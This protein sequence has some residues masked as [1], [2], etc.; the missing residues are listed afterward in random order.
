MAEANSDEKTE[1]P[2]AKKISKAREEGNVPKSQDVNGFVTMTVAVAGVILLASQIGTRSVNLFNYYFSIMNTELTMDNAMN[3]ALVSFKEFLLIVLPLTF[4]VAT[5]GVI[6]TIGQ[7]GWLFTTKAIKPKFSKLNPINGLKNLIS[8]KKFVEGFK[9]IFKSFTMLI[10]G[11][12]FFWGFVEELPTVVLFDVEAQLAWMYDKVLI[13]VF[14]MLFIMLIYALIDFA[15]TKYNYT[16]QLKMTKQEVKDEHK[17]SEGDPKIKAKIR[18]MQYEMVQKRMMANVPDADVVITNPTHYAV[19]LKYDSEINRAPF[20]TAKGADHIALQI[21][22]IARENGVPV[23]QNPPLARSLYDQV[24]L[25]RP[26]P[27]ELFLAV[28]EVLAYVMKQNK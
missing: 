8:V 1:D 17:N 2:T 18:Q 4:L 10:I 16:K 3:I 20:V 12:M 14:V 26:I 6:A 25:D 22:K 28:A 9:I 13:L 11:A 23:V 21:K 5:A 15:I 24:D 19:A 7:I 27:D